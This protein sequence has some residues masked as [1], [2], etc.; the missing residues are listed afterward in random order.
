[1][2]KKMKQVDLLTLS[3]YSEQP[4]QNI[5]QVAGTVSAPLH[6]ILERDDKDGKSR[7]T[8]SA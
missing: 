2:K 8:S 6:S 3:L 1:M 5:D 4:V 7:N